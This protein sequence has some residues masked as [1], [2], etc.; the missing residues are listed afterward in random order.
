MPPSGCCASCG[1]PLHALCW[2][3]ALGGERAA[4]E[5]GR[6]PDGV[7]RW[8]CVAP[9]CRAPGEVGEPDPPKRRKFV[10]REVRQRRPVSA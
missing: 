3:L 2:S 8:V 6:N 7:A 1:E 5:A 9:G 4:I 10:G